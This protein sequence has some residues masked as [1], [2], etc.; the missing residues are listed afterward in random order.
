[1]KSFV[2]AALAITGTA[3]RIWIQAPVLDQQVIPGDDLVIEIQSEVLPFSSPDKQKLRMSRILPLHIQILRPPS[4][5]SLGPE[6]PMTES[7][8]NI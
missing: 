3:Q 7:W 8:G 6:V 5:F 1:M 2:F 4:A